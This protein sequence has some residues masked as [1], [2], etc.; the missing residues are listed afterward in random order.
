MQ[1]MKEKQNFISKQ[2]PKKKH[3]EY[4]VQMKQ[5]KRVRDE[6]MEW[7]RQFAQEINH[8]LD[9]EEVVMDGK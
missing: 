7:L 5:E 6:A 9:F 3:T 4:R 2:L 8:L 1:Q